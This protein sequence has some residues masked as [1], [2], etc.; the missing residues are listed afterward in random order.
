MEH[1]KCPAYPDCDKLEEI[2]TLDPEK[3]DIEGLTSDICELCD[4][5]VKRFSAKA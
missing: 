5:E 4:R 1:R 2:R 3:Y